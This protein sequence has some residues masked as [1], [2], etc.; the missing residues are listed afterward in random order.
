MPQIEHH[1]PHFHYEVAWRRNA[2][3]YQY[4]SQKIPKWEQSELV[5]PNVPTFVEF[6]V[7]V[8]AKNE[9]GQA[10]APVQTVKGYSGED[11]K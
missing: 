2:P 8:T 3:G 6:E 11:S 7:K 10:R 9:R 5:I 4:E 1:A